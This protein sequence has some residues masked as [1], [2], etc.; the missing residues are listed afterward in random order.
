MLNPAAT[1]AIPQR[2]K[3]PQPKPRA[4]LMT[5]CANATSS[6]VADRARMGAVS[7]IAAASV[8]DSCLTV[9]QP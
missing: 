7:F 8:G 1:P 5:T 9:D 4:P 2:G 6:R 3:G